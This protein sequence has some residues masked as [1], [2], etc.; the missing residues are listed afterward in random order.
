MVVC[1]FSVVRSLSWCLWGVWWGQSS[2]QEA[3]VLFQN[4]IQLIRVRLCANAGV[5]GA[6]N[7]YFGQR[8][9][10]MNSTSE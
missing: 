1:G 8:K 2:G 7:I 4:V 3:R 10:D 5:Q 9:I 6:L